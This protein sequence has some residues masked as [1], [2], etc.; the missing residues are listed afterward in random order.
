VDWSTDLSTF[1][2]QLPTRPQTL[3]LG[4]ISVDQVYEAGEP[5]GSQTIDAVAMQEVGMDDSTRQDYN[6][7]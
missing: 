5:S 2:T 3:V 7:E 1:K 6:G 4:N